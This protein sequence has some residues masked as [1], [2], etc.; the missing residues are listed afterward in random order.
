MVTGTHIVQRMAKPTLLTSITSVTCTDVFHDM[1]VVS[2]LHIYFPVVSYVFCHV[3]LSFVPSF[4]PSFL[5]LFLLFCLSRDVQCCSAICSNRSLIVTHL[6]LLSLCAGLTF[7]HTHDRQLHMHV[8]APAHIAID[9][10]K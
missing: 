5:W 6:S 3:N 4:V 2:L 10:V 9:A 8:C 1:E 7:G